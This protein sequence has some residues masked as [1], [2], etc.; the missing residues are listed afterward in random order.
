MAISSLLGAVGAVALGCFLY[1]YLVYPM[2]FSPL[3]KAPCAHWSAA[4]SPLWM[5]WIR[6]KLRENR[7]IWNAHQQLGPVVRLGPNELS[8]NDYHGGLKTIYVGGFEKIQ[9]YANMFEN[10]GE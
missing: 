4:F 5:L 6:F 7:T 10:Y 9:W 3:A 2:F 8:V 1:K